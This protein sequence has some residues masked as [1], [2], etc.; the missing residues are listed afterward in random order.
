MAP[1]IRFLA[2]IVFGATAVLAADASLTITVHADR[3]AAYTVPRTIFG[4]FLE[5]IGNST[6]NGLWAEILENPS[7][8][9]GMWSAPNVTR[10]VREEPSL[11]RASSLD[12]PLPW[13]P[14]YSNQGNRYEQHRGDAA[15]SWQ[16]I[17]VFGLEGAE[18]GIKQQVFLPVHR[19]LH[20][21]ASIYAKHLSG[22]NG[23][24]IS[25]RIRNKPDEKLAAT[26]IDSLTGDWKKYSVDL[27]VPE[28]RLHRLDP[29]DF[30]IAVKGNERVLL[31]QA[32]LVPADAVDGMDPDMIR[33]TQEMHTPLVRFG[34]NFTSGYHW[35]DGVGPMDKRVSMLNQAWGIP[36]LNQFG[37]D[38]FLRFCKLIN[39]EPQIALNLG[40]GT[41][42]EA[43][44]W[45]RYV[46]QHGDRHSGL[47]WELGN[48]LWGNW[49]MGYP[50]LNE[51][52]SRTLAFS[53]AIR[54]ADPNAML[55]AT[56]QDPDHYQ[57]WNAAQ[58]TNPA[59]TF[60]YLSTHFVVTTDNTETGNASPD[61][62]AEATFALPIELGRKL[63][64]MQEQI[65]GTPAFRD[66]AHIAFTEWLYVCCR[67][68]L[69]DAPRFTNMG[70]AI[71]AAGFLDMLLQNAD[72]VPISDMT[73]IVEFG[74]VWKT[75][76]QVYGTPAYYAFRMYSTADVSKTVA[77]DNP[78]PTYSVHKGVTRLPEIADVP[79]LDVV[80]A[81]N[82][83]GDRLTLF[84]VN[85][86]LTRDI[87]ARIN[88]GGFRVSGE[89]HVTQLYSDSIYDVNDEMRPTHITPMESTAKVDGG[90]V[91]F[92]FRHE[93]VVRIEV[94]RR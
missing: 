63:R 34:G 57:Q 66:K 87:T 73:G 30:V 35:R 90:G 40:S 27:T 31:D 85:R 84:C 58:L 38:E 59:G 13:E 19:E 46:N 89:A 79:Y 70:G 24:E 16:A 28:G 42:E 71:G 39:A 14:L 25:L 1:I 11:L 69:I 75:R 36:E 93:S 76:S 50:T 21:R 33:M 72:V 74:G 53:K 83:T 77:V 86:S 26:S 15:N 9:N 7:M 61:F 52:P 47:L 56:G 91:D 60:N 37:T 12:L 8:E 3:P 80:A 43:A 32:S 41:P 22:D 54:Q 62:K 48:E 51:L 81:I 55:I 67:G 78:S 6:Y 45:V 2:V 68:G 88:L 64:A 94:A 18:T 49:N 17:A 10:M 20:Y 4:T 44:D 82:K 5:P 23:L 92:M 65:N 29:A